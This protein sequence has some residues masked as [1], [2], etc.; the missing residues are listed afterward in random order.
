MPRFAILEHDYPIL[1]WDL[2][3]ESGPVL[4]TWRLS[5]PPEPDKRIEAVPSF[6]HRLLYL[7][8][9]GPISG[10]RGQVKRWDTGTFAWEQE[11]PE[12]IAVRLEGRRL[13]GLAILERDDPS[14]WSLVVQP[15][16]RAQEDLL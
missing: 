7:D 10:G 5:A 1:H 8:Y 12:R 3:L 2:L 11:K 16:Q 6:D 15:D 14:A 9:E 13:A 4:R